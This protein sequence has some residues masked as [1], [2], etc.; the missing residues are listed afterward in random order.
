MFEHILR[1]DDTAPAT[2][3]LVFAVTMN[4]KLTGRVVSPGKRLLRLSMDDLDN[5]NLVMKTLEELNKVMKE[6][7]VVSF[8]T[9]HGVKMFLPR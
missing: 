8:C 3:S 1:S 2:V 6:S 7:F 5:R 9:V 4:Y